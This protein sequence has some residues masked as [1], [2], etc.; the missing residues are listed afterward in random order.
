MALW[1]SLWKS[2]YRRRRRHRRHPNFFSITAAEGTAPP[3]GEGNPAEGVCSA[4]I[5]KRVGFFFGIS[6]FV[7]I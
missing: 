5:I 6:S 4:S 7:S 1:K 3:E 2:F